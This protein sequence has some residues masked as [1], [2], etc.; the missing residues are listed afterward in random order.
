[1]DCAW[2]IANCADCST[3]DALPKLHGLRMCRAPRNLVAFDDGI[4]CI[5]ILRRKI[6]VGTESAAITECEVRDLAVR[7]RCLWRVA[8]R[9][10]DDHIG[11][12]IRVSTRIELR[13]QVELA[14]LASNPSK[15][16]RLDRA[17]VSNQTLVAR[18]SADGAA[19]HVAD[20][21]DRR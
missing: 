14:L 3:L 10:A 4:G 5:V 17:V 18:R 8:K 11:I 1:M 13:P 15:G 19:G 9:A 2:C 7:A 16:A 21:L 20:D 12:V 6:F